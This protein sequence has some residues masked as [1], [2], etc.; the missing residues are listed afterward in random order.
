MFQSFSVSEEQLV[1]NMSTETIPIVKNDS[2]LIIN[3][4]NQ[5]KVLMPILSSELQYEIIFQMS[6]FSQQNILIFPTLLP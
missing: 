2:G 5:N 6:F 4:S 3:Q 1:S